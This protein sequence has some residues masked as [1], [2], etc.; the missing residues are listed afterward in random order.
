[1]IACLVI[2]LAPVWGKKGKGKRRGNEGASGLRCVICQA[3]A[4][5]AQK[6]WEM[7]KTT[8]SGSA[9][10]YLDDKERGQAPEDIVSESLQ[11]KVCNRG[12]LGQI[13]NPKGY[14]KHAP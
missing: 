2:L 6:T 14:A 3:M 1:M 4:Y 13:P 10:N 12:Y 5:E 11:R 9:Y 7:A 8:K